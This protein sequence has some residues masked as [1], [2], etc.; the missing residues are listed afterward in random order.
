MC[1]CVGVRVPGDGDATVSENSKEK[2]PRS[3][4]DDEAALTRLVPPQA[5]A[6][7]TGKEWGTPGDATTVEGLVEGLVDAEVDADDA[8][9]EDDEENEE[10]EE[11]EDR[12][13][14]D[15]EGKGKEEAL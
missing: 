4:G 3:I 11:E 2:V 15:S 1:C 7:D 5:I 14:N 9:E 8:D 12:G 6:I 13:E 10:E